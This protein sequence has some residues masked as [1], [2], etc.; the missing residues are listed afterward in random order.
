MT[1]PAVEATG[2][3]APTGAG[4]S[5]VVL[6]HPRTSA[7]TS[8]VLGVGRDLLDSGVGRLSG[9]TLTLRAGDRVVASLPLGARMARAVRARGAVFVLVGAGP[10]PAGPP[11]EVIPR[12]RTSGGFGSRGQVPVVL[13]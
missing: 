12:Y 10:L 9:S 8:H 11:A 5:A 3:V 4:D 1:A 13:P 6:L 2:W 7:W